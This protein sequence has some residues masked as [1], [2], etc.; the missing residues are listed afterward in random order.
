[1]YAF[2]SNEYRTIVY[3]QRQLDFL[4]GVYSYPQFRKVESIA[5][6]KKF[7]NSCN[8][9]FINTNLS[10][11]GKTLNVGYLSVEY[12]IDNNN[13]YVNIDTKHFGFIKLFN[14]PSNIKQDS[15]YD[16]IKLKICNVAL[17]DSLIAHHCVAIQNI[18][19]VLDDY[20]NVELV[21]PDISVYLA[22]EK[23][24]G[25]N[26]MINRLQ[27]TVAQR[28]GQVFYSMR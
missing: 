18:L 22:C 4:L 26:F 11:Y 28:P 3:S 27:G 16:L 7:F 8:R 19:S 24:K 12:F 23:Y 14:L 25:N 17:D 13:I 5:D 20:V 21:L 10:K 6:A 1:M 9:E 2:V 15:S